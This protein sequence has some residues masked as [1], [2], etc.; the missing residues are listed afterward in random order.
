MA[1]PTYFRGYSGLRACT[2]RT[3]HLHSLTSQF[4]RPNYLVYVNTLL[5]VLH[6]A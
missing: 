1:T 5:L 2:L 3:P 4:H 6:T